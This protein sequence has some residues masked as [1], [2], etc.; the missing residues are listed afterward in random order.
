VQQMDV[1]A[2]RNLTPGDRAAL[3]R[4]LDAKAIASK[5]RKRV[6]KLVYQGKS[7]I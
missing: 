5:K 6:C 3:V 4:K 7:L 1:A 2:L